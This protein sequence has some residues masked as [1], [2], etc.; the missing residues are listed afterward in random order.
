MEAIYGLIRFMFIAWILKVAGLPLLRMIIGLTKGIKLSSMK[1]YLRRKRSSYF[2]KEVLN[3]VYVGT[4]I[5]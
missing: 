3:T 4:R 5:C 2:D 1:T